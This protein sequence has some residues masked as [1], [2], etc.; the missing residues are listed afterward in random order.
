MDQTVVKISTPADI[1]GILPHRLGFHPTESLV[2]V[3]LHGP[4]RRDELVMRLDLPAAGHDAALCTEVVAR[5][6]KQD[7]DATLL[8]AYTDGPRPAYGLLRAPLVRRLRRE[9]RAAGIEVVD[10]LLVRKGRWWSYLCRP[11]RCCPP[12][13]T[14]LPDRPTPA[15]LFFAAESVGR[16]A[17]VR[18]DRDA[19]R[20]SV[21]TA[22][23]DHRLVD[24][25]DEGLV[26]QLL[27]LGPGAVERSVLAILARL[28][29]AWEQ[30][31]CTVADTDALTVGL[32]LRGK[33]LRDRVMTLVLD[34]EP[35]L[36]VA[37]FGELVRR[38]PDEDAAGVCC[39]LAWFAYAAGDGALAVV[40]AERALRV[41][42][43]YQMAE[44]I[45]SGLAAMQP[46]TIVRE[47]S[48]LVR[49]DL[50]LSDDGEDDLGDL[51]GLG[52]LDAAS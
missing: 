16:G 28:M 9:L 7:A 17:V 5:L 43:G 12:E 40:A 22:A 21:E 45:L 52:D 3:S 33:H 18:A 37:L 2:V 51:G 24:E 39:A 26:D 1:I 8:V 36:L 47:I 6:V 4:R 38:T 29:R 42:P 13:G 11:G 44:L 32:A 20:S 19:L 46:P 27:R 14:A 25:V 10:A 49:N 41:S 30:G 50:E 34:H 15:T 48:T 35:G 31:D 23:V